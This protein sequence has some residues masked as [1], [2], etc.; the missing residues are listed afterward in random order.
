[1]KTYIQID[2]VWGKDLEGNFKLLIDKAI[3]T[4]NIQFS[5]KFNGVMLYSDVDTLD[6]AY[7]KVTGMSYDEHKAYLQKPHDEYQEKLKKHLDAI[8][9]L[10][11]Q[12]IEDG[13]KFLAPEYH[14]LWAEIVPIRLGDLYRGMELQCV[15]DL[16]PL[17]DNGNYVEA[18]ALLDEQGHSG[19]SYHLVLAMLSAFHKN[20][21][22]FVKFVKG[23]DGE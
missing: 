13:N 15:K 9:E 5:M 17:L 14:E 4:P 21:D 7:Q 6:S 2:P 20:G 23:V 8:P 12:W 10:T 16:V 18:K 11:K 19:M 3:E 22:A 1:M